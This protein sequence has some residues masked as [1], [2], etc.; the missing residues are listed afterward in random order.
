MDNHWFN[1]SLNY[2]VGIGCFSTYKNPCEIFDSC[3][4]QK[5]A[6]FNVSSSIINGLL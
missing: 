4:T 3:Q 2:K 6:P 5:T 1:K